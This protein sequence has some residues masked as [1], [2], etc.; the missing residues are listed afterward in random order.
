[1]T[2]GRRWAAST[3]EDELLSRLYQQVTEQ[4]A[5]Q[6]ASGYDMAAGL[7]RYCAWLAGHAI[8]ESHRLKATQQQGAA[9]LRAAFADTSARTVSAA[10]GA[11]VVLR[12]T[13]QRST[14]GEAP[15]PGTDE[16]AAR[17]VTAIYTTHYRSLVR[18]AVLLV[19]D[20]ATAEEI[21]QDSFIATHCAWRRLGDT[22][23][24]LT[25][26][27]RSVVNRSR[28]ILRHQAVADKIA[29]ELA[30]DLPS[31]E[32][33]AL[34]LLERSAVISALQ[35]LP[36][37]Q[38]EVMVLRYYA[39]LSDAQIASAMGISMGAVK[40]HAARGMSSLRAALDPSEE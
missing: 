30:P 27:R 1:M 37:R 16:D 15:A 10:I 28:S 6:F 5:A 31:A 11:P 39:G 13:A 2:R 38:R 33:D 24:A 40:H 25:Y 34:S 36:S 32:E 18:L 12:R 19:R 21:V 17:A 14:R 3:G 23:K 29:P 20:V 22:E 7:N 26:L 35:T 4:Q 8:E 9:A